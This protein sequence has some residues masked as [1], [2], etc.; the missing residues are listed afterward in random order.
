MNAPPKVTI[1]SV[2]PGYCTIM[3]G[4]VQ[5][6][7]A[8]TVWDARDPLNGA[9]EAHLWSVAGVHEADGVVVLRLRLTE[10]RA[11]LRRRLAEDGPWWKVP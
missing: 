5:V 11:E 1:V 7:Y 8:L 4:R 10:L 6:G 2:E 9:W 3:S